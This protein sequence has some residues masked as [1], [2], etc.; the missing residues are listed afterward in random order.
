M[1]ISR[2]SA[3]CFFASG[4][5][6]LFLSGADL[7]GQDA[8]AADNRPG[9]AVLPFENGG[10]YGPDREDME[11]L[12]VGLQ[13]MLLSELS[14]NSSLRVIERRALRELLEEQEFG[15][16]GRVQAGTAAELGRVLGARFI[17]IGVFVDLFSD[18]RMDV[19]VVD[20]E[21]SE[22]LN[23]HTVRDN[24]S[25][26]GNLLVELAA[27]VTAGADLPPLEGSIRQSREAREIPAEAIILYSRAQ[28][29]EDFGDRERAGEVYRRI[30]QDFPEMTEAHEA[31]RQLE[32]N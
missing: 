16:S 31:L 10:S 24:R 26:L 15:A 8:A 17:V 28:T 2:T 18:F 25:N 9:V 6:L 4:L 23:S 21:T 12:T 5:L 29:Y 27:K 20:V 1:G 19:R 11:A 14:Q 7:A 32:G 30:V 13:G 22:I 3:T